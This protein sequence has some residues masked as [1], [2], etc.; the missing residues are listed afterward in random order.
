MKHT[1][2]QNIRNAYKIYERMQN[3]RSLDDVYTTYSSDKQEAFSYCMR[4]FREYDGRNPRVIGHNTFSFSFGFI[5]LYDGVLTFFYIT[6]EHIYY[7]FL[8][9]L[10]E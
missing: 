5:G 7:A 8:Y 9:E 1:K 3:T 4:L 6:K 10:E 2:A